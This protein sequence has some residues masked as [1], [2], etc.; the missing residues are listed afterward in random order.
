MIDVQKTA[1]PVVR[2]RLMIAAVP[3]AAPPPPLPVCSQQAGEAC[4]STKP[5]YVA[6]LVFRVQMP[7][8]VR[9]NSATPGSAGDAKM[10]TIHAKAVAMFSILTTVK[11]DVMDAAEE[12]QRKY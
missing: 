8:V 7:N 4:S 10:S 1:L 9:E 11:R 12:H 6:M 2:L 3:T 5:T